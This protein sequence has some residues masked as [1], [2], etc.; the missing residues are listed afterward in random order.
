M[1]PAY[2][3]G[4]TANRQSVQR[5]EIVRFVQVIVPNALMVWGADLNIFTKPGCNHVPMGNIQMGIESS[6]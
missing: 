2:L 1:F 5:E 4:I 6:L 3:A